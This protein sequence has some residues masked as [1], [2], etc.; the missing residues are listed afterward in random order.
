[1]NRL[2]F[3][4]ALLLSALPQVFATPPPNVILIFADDLGYG[5]L[6]CFGSTT[7]RTPHLDR[8]AAEGRKFTSF[9]VASSVCSPSRAALLTGSYPKRV[10]MHEGVLFPDSQ[11]GLN[12]AEYTLADHFKSL[13]YATACIGKWHLGDQPETLP[14]ANG[15]DTY[16]GIPYSN[17]MNHPD[18]KGKPPGGVAG[19]DALWNDPESTLTKWKTPLME[20]G[21]IIE[22][23]VD[24]RTLTRRYTD[25][26]I[27]FVEKNRTRPFFIYLPHA[28]P[29]IPLY[30]PDDVRDPNPKHAYINTIEHLDTE[31]GR[32][33]EKLR[34]LKLA[35]STYVI[36]TSDNGPWL[37]FKHHGG[38][39]GP[40]RGGKT[41]VFEGGHR[42]PCIVWAPGRVPAGTECGALASTLDVLPTMAALTQTPLPLGLEIDGLD[43]SRLLTGEAKTVR[44]DFL[45][46]TMR[47]RLEGIREGDWKLL[48]RQPDSKQPTEAAAKPEVLLF[49]LT[50]DLGEMT[51]R[52]ASRPELVERLKTKMQDQDAAI[53][54]SAR[55]AWKAAVK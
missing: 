41:S 6:G 26:A 22:L 49:N 52:A 24:Q 19:M 28:M 31:V 36:F 51:N 40:L 7:I 10:G 23:P 11:K 44:E 25:K 5:D 55:P 38:S 29:H 21:K 3:T 33:F 9:V 32:L 53:T 47:G 17:D 1:M 43:I 35:E 18:N 54:A 2:L 48:V 45:Y 20:D 34:E 46:Y 27:G 8:L 12:P 30:V 50:D 4:C 15:F 14:T 13:G 16:Y 42:V 39:A 37:T